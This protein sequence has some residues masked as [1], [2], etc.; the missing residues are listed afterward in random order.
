M[1]INEKSQQIKFKYIYLLGLLITVGN[2]SSPFF[3]NA[4]INLGFISGYGAI[5]LDVIPFCIANFLLDIF[6]NQYGWQ[7]SR[8][9]VLYIILTR[10][11]MAVIMWLMLLVSPIEHFNQDYLSF[12]VR[13]LVSGVVAGLIA[14]TL[15]CYIFF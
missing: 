1:D 12:V 11:V 9:L 4:T 5:L 14:L 2:I 8:K 13:G 3:G 15:N 6:T 7:N 10:I